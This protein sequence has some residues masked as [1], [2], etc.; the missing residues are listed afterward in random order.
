MRTRRRLVAV[1]AATFTLGA[2]ALHAQAEA[3]RGKVI[4][5]CSGTV[6]CPPVP[7]GTPVYKSISL[8]VSHAKNG[9]WV[10]VWPGWYREA[11]TVEP[12]AQLTSGLHV[13]GMNRNGVVLD[14]KSA[15]GSGIHVSG[16]DSTWVENMTA[17]HYKAG[18][19]NGFYWTGVDGFWG[20]YL[21]AY[22]NGSYGVYAYDSTSSSAAP[23]AF[24]NVY[25]SWNGDSG[26]Y[27]GGCRDCNTV[28][29]N[30]RA[31]KNAIGYSGTNAGGELYLINSE[32][33]HNGS[34]VVPNSESSE[35][36]IP[37]QG[38]TIAGNY[39][40]DNNDNDVPGNLA[41]F[42]AIAPLGAGVVIAGG[43]NNVVRHNLIK[44]QKHA[45]VLMHWFFT[46]PVS[47]QVVYNTFV[48]AG[49]AGSPVG[50]DTDIAMDGS[51]L[52]NCIEGNV[53]R[54]G[55]TSEPATVDP[56]NPV[57]LTSCT[58]NPLRGS[59]LGRGLYTPGDPLVS[60]MT[61]LNAAGV[62]EPRDYQG[63]GPRPGALVTMA[64]PCAG[65]PANP[66]CRD[67]KPVVAPPSAP[68]R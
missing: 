67:G 38:A 49:N 54:T 64:N 6:T 55:T 68:G 36:D 45:G 23:S 25:G 7:R 22:D 42:T 52:H 48:N 40:H 31:Y 39:I 14:G 63:P 28:V 50:G 65:V 51:S 33:D 29:T 27:V 4:L 41:G 8:G 19:S 1:L 16:V 53:R 12:N 57:G 44:N 26:I 24:A 61:A 11:V 3:P 30:S 15:S 34:G 10:L 18:S 37:Q 62:T 9:D 21:T 35:P 60:I 20:R 13:R 66:W 56:P 47:N 43:W 2:L 59:P 17:Q 58:S 46:P 5:V 32:W